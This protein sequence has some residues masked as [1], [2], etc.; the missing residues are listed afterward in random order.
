M[1]PG[2]QGDRLP[3][4][5]RVRPGYRAAPGGDRRRAGDAALAGLV[6]RRGKPPSSSRARWPASRCSPAWSCSRGAPSPRCC[7]RSAPRTT[8]WRSS[9]TCLFLAAAALFAGTNG[10][11]LFVI[12][13]F[14]LLLYLPLGKLRHAVF[15]WAARADLGLRLGTPRGLSARPDSHGAHPWR[16]KR[17]PAATRPARRPGNRRAPRPA[18]RDAPSRRLR[19]ISRVRPGGPLARAMRG[20]AAYHLNA[21]VKCGLCGETCHI[22]QA[23]PVPENLPGAKAAKVIAHYNRY[24]TLLGRV[25]PGWVGAKD[26][27]PE[28]LDEAGRDGLRPLHG[29]RALRAALLDRPR[30]G[31]DHPRRSQRAG[32]RGQGGPRACSARSPTSS[33]PATRWRS[34]VRSS[35]RRPSG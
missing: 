13:A 32:P 15:F 27:T 4:R 18:S 23:E 12:C 11:G 31:G 33:R 10:H 14:F 19:R 7:E 1:D 30:R 24:H 35:S 28:A 3:A 8:S 5:G 21:C 6:P 16:M 26:F 20:R 2:A 29:L 17:S 22:Y 25:A 9:A 34:R